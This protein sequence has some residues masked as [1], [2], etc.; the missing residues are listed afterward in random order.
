MKKGI[1]FIVFLWLGFFL[2]SVVICHFVIGFSSPQMVNLLIS[3]GISGLI[4][5]GVLALE[6]MFGLEKRFVAFE[7]RLISIEEKFV[8]RFKSA[9]EQFMK[10]FKL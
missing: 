6:K 3:W 8:E 1:L 5:G 9:E 2:T 4:M 10:K 7:E